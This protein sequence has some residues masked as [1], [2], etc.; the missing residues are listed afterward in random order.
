M[1]D[2]KVYYTASDFD[3]DIN[4][5]LER[6]AKE[7]NI[8]LVSLY[9]GS[10]PLGVR[11]SNITSAPLSIIQFQTRDG[12]DS[13]PKLVVDKEIKPD[14]CI[15]L[16]DDIL[17][18]GLTLQKTYEFMRKKYPKNKIIGF[19]LFLNLQYNILLDWCTSLN[20]SEGEWIV[21]EPWEVAIK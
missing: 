3:R 4:L 12:N 14:E 18:T 17:D 15:V 20:F 21:F 8:H 5:I 19:T 10:L 2:C 7:E 9:R 1:D 6:L 11:L 13:E 16:L